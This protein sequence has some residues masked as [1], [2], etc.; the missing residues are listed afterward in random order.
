MLR[1][2]AQTMPRGMC[3]ECPKQSQP[4]CGLQAASPALPHFLCLQVRLS[5]CCQASALAIVTSACFVTHPDTSLPS[6]TSHPSV[7]MSHMLCFSVSCLS[8]PP[9]SSL[10]SPSASPSCQ[11]LS[12][13]LYPLPESSPYRF[14]SLSHP[15]CPVPGPDLEINPTLESLCV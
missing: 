6:H 7:Y 12:S 11:P 9:S 10:S 13:R 14:C 4:V 2:D 1:A 5:L 15:D 8:S 3:C